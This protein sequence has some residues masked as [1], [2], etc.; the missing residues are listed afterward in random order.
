VA[1]MAKEMME[2]TKM[3]ILQQAATAMLEILAA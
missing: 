2:F 3:N 1:T